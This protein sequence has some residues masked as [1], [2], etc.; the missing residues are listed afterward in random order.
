MLRECRGGVVGNP[1]VGDYG[2]PIELEG[3]HESRGHDAKL[4]AK[5][6][7]ATLVVSAGALMT[8]MHAGHG[9]LRSAVTTVG[10]VRRM[11]RILRCVHYRRRRVSLRLAMRA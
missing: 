3:L 8:F 9:G 5:A 7:A 4:A 6:P 2:A 10:V 11:Y 1:V